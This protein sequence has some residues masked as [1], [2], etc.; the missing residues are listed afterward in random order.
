MKYEL[1]Y[2]I[3]VRDRNGKVKSRKR[4]RSRSFLKQWNQ[5]VYIQMREATISVTDTGGV[6]RSTARHKNH[7]VMEGGVGATAY[8]IRVGTGSTAVAIA[9]YAL[10]TPIAEGAA[11]GQMNHGAT[12]A[13]TSVLSAP[14]AYFVVSRTM[15]N[16]S[17]G[18]ITVTEA[19]IYGRLG[20]S[21]YCCLTREVFAGELVVD[22]DTITIN[23]TIQV[24]A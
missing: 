3:I 12:V 23:W 20:V 8:G 19:A 2:E 14:S 4:R 17:G 24:T 16:N 1:W 9:D 13:A 7:F 5:I 22:T 21:Y 18:P 11:A 6:G 10:E 15:T